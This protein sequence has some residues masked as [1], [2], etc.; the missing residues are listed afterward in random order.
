M[1][2]GR[3]FCK[4]KCQGL[5]QS[6][7][8]TLIS[9]SQQREDEKQAHSVLG[10]SA[11]GRHLMELLI[12]SIWWLYMPLSQAT[13]PELKLFTSADTIVSRKQINEIWCF[14]LLQLQGE[15]SAE[16]LK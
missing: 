4:I 5:L 13:P 16:S 3:L 1:F 12:S 15:E 7:C 14:V 6:S 9:G 11:W 8:V 2:E 10:L